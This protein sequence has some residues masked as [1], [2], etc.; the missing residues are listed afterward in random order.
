MI[1]FSISRLVAKVAGFTRTRKKLIEELYRD[2]RFVDLFWVGATN[3]DLKSKIFNFR[4]LT[5]LRNIQYFKTWNL[6]ILLSF[7]YFSGSLLPSWIRMHNT[8]L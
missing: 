5:Y 8:G 4:F 7:F 2:A 1:K 3:E 6:I